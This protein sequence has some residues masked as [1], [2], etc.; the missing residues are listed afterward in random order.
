MLKS[1]LSKQRTLFVLGLLCVL[2]AI[3]SEREVSCS[4]LHSSDISDVRVGQPVLD[5]E[6]EKCCQPQLRTRCETHTMWSCLPDPE[7]TRC[8]GSLA[9]LDKCTGHTCNAATYS[10]ICKI[11]RGGGF[12]YNQCV[13]TGG[14]TACEG[15]FTCDYVHSS[16]VVIYDRCAYQGDICIWAGDICA[17]W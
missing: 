17:M 6:L 1:L 7:N 13:G 8:T 15:G 9:N 5:T 2:L 3:L 10:N 16:A 12:V 11:L 4:P 14:R